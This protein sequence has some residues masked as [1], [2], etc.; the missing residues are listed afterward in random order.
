MTGTVL[1]G[2]EHQEYGEVVARGPSRRTGVALTR[3]RLPK[4]YAAVDANEDVVGAVQTDDATLLVV[5]D[6]H[7]GE[8]A[9]ALAVDAVLQRFGD[10][11]PTRLS[12]ADLVG[13]FCDVDEAVVSGVA[14][15][16]GGRSE[17]RTT[18]S[19][20]VVRGTSLRWAA[21][22]D[23][24]VLVGG[25]DDASEL[26]EGR[27]DFLG[28]P[29][30]VH[31]MDRLLQR[32]H[33]EIPMGGWVAVCSDGFSNFRL[34]PSTAAAAQQVLADVS[35][36]RRAAKLLVEAANRAGAGTTTSRRR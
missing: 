19:L 16:R 8:V 13:L 18:L 11:V 15:D 9:S 32:G 26:T 29:I 3:G 21:L 5:A 36:A 30:P 2:S 20:A 22:G 35:D 25:L 10:E 34:A 17:S 6:G 7:N 4:P 31:L 24:P 12:D 1:W 33:A 23:S 28:W 27:H 14:G